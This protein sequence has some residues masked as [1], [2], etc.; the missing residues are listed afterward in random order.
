V[1]TNNDIG[2]ECAQII[3]KHIY[4]SDKQKVYEYSFEK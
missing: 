4:I 3:N 1:K 2:I